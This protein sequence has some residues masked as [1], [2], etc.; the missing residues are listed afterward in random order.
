MANL[1]INDL[2]H[3]SE[4]DRK[5]M[6]G[7]R[8]GV[9]VNWSGLFASYESLLAAKRRKALSTINNVFNFNRSPLS[10]QYAPQTVFGGEGTTVAVSA[11]ESRTANVV[12]EIAEGDSPQH[13]CC[14]CGHL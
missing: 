7:V 1:V 11:P 9:F 3:H 13:C 2:A 6:A 5:A 12:T 14:R 4:L 8:G 10:I